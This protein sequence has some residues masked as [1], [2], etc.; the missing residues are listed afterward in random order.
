[1]ARILITHGYRLV[2]DPAELA[3]GKPYPPLGTLLSAGRLRDAGH[4]IYVHDATFDADIG[5]FRDTLTRYDPDLVF[6]LTDNLAVP[7]QMCTATLRSATLELVEL[8]SSEG[9]PVLVSAPDVTNHP[10]PY[11]E[12]GGTWAVR[13]DADSVLLAIA[14]GKMAAGEVSPEAAL[15]D[16]DVLPCPPWEL[17]D[18]APYR[19]T[20]RQR[21][22]HWELNLSTS[23]G[24]P[25]RCNWCAKPVWGR[26]YNVRSPER[27]LEDLQHTLSVAQPDR[28]WFT[29]DIFAIRPNWLRA[30]ADG[31]EGAGIRVPFR[32]LSRVDLLRDDSFTHDLARSGCREVWVGA[33]SGSQTVL[34]A[35]DKDCTVTDIARA[36]QLLHEHQIDVGF[37]LQ[38]GYPGEGLDEVFETL[39]M[40]RTLRPDEIGVSVS[41]PLPGT[42]FHERVREQMRQDAWDASMEC[43]VLFETPFSQRFYNLVKKTLASEHRVANLPRSAIAFAKRPSRFTGRRLAGTFFH[44]ARLPLLHREIRKE[45]Q[46]PRTAA[47]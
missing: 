37:F 32:C 11:L 21:H 38:L 8:A 25:Y 2:D 29:D 22:G 17:I 1:M 24:C 16:L 30:F 41:Y 10:E 20:W 3:L 42:I 26:T 9:W 12:A 40:V 36:T 18:L 44:A 34:D 47:P 15:T 19:E 7:P 23:R 45:A 27:T 43:D 46:A 35:M 13:G 28:I 14:E 4:E 39:S 31:V 5:P 6:V 33:E